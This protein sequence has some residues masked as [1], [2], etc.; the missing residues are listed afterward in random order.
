MNFLIIL[1]ASFHVTKTTWRT[2]KQFVTRLLEHM[3]LANE[4]VRPT[5]VMVA[6]EAK[7][8]ISFDDYG[9]GDESKMADIKRAVEHLEQMH[10]DYRWDVA[11][12][13]ASR[14]SH[15]SEYIEQRNI[16]LFI[17]QASQINM[18]RDMLIEKARVMK[19]NGVGVF[20]V[21]LNP[22]NVDAEPYLSLVS[23]PV[24]KHFVDLPTTENMTSW[25]TT[26]ARAVCN[27]RVQVRG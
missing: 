9:Y 24:A 10:G 26:I 21:L 6:N 5:V 27:S 15:S 17:K 1:D 8:A 18:N 7:L 19:E 2:M 25:S 3:K 20:N 14:L 23:R 12:E 11:M 22:D 13:Y 4:A 16:V